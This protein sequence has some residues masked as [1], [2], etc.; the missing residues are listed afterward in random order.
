MPEFEDALST[1]FRQATESVRP[2]KPLRLVSEAHAQGRRIRR[3]R[4]VAVVSTAVAV[5]AAVAIGGTVVATSASGSHRAGTIVADPANPRTA[6]GKRDAQ[7][8]DAFTALLTPGTLAGIQS[9][10]SDPGEAQQG[11]AP[12]AGIAAKFTNSRGT[13]VVS[14][15]VTRKPAGSEPSRAVCPPVRG[16][17]SDGPCHLFAYKDGRGMVSQN[18]HPAPADWLGSYYETA[19]YQVTIGQN[20]LRTPHHSNSPTTDAPLTVAQLTSIAE[21]DLW[22]DIAAGMPVPPRSAMVPGRLITTESWS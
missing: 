17:D 22:R 14:V 3:R 2:D 20:W 6:Q 13:A 19:D 21:S 15:F 9:E 5:A 4:K 8:R 11:V 1:A 16:G 10:D 18:I 12:A 7:M